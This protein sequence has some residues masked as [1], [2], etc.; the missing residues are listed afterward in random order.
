MVSSSSLS[1]VSEEFYKEVRKLEIRLEDYLKDED[2]FVKNLRD[3]IIQFEELHTFIEKLRK[4]PD[5]KKIGEVL[6]LKTK[7]V[8]AFSEAI[9]NEGKAEH[10]RSHLLESYGALILAL[11]KIEDNLDINHLHEK[12]T[13]DGI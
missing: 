10:E 11:Q 13:V 9:S 3:C 6:K 5:A 1:E 4:S 2:V 7:G 8:E 12:P